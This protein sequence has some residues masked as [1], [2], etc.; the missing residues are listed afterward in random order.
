MTKLVSVCQ[1]WSIKSLNVKRLEA[2]VVFKKRRRHRYFHVSFA[3]FLRTPFLENTIGRLI[4]K[5]YQLSMCKLVAEDAHWVKSVQL[6]TYF[7]FVFSCIWTVCRKIQT[8]KN[9]VFGHFSRSAHQSFP[10]SKC[11]NQTVIL[12]RNHFWLGDSHLQAKLTAVRVNVNNAS[13]TK[14][15]VF[16]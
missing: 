4:L 1:I 11:T 10:F 2:A 13:C 16:H 12:L 6:R 8:R 14:N 5:V 3:K 15:E 7:W 9:S